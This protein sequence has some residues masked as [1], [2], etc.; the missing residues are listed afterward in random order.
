MAVFG[1]AG[2]VGLLFSALAR[3][4]GGNVSA[5]LPGRELASLLLLLAG[6]LNGSSRLG[7]I[8]CSRS[9]ATEVVDNAVTGRDSGGSDDHGG[10][11]WFS[12]D[13]TCDE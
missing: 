8:C 3:F 12:A 4:K 10:R 9:S 1:L 13:D 2:N 6:R 7:G 11:I 5:E